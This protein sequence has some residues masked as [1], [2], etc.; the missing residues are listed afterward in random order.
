[1]SASDVVLKGELPVERVADFVAF[2][3][4]MYVSTEIFFLWSMK[5]LFAIFRIVQHHKLWEFFFHRL[6][7]ET[8]ICRELVVETAPAASVPWP[9]PLFEGCPD[10]WWHSYV[11]PSSTTRPLSTTTTQETIGARSNTQ[12]TIPSSPLP[13]TGETEKRK[14]SPT[15]STS[16]KSDERR[17]LAVEK[18][19]ESTDREMVKIIIESATKETSSLIEQEM[20]AKIRERENA[21]LSKINQVHKTA[22]S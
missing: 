8:V 21:V 14:G 13:K 15:K 18:A 22:E 11:C 17:I 2:L 9:P 19:L 4:N 3:S 12:T 1:M 20:K 10:Q 6:H 16:A 5:M 7:E